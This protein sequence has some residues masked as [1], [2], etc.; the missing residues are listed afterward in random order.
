[1][2]KRFNIKPWQLILGVVLLGV[3]IYCYIANTDITNS[4]VASGMRFGM[5]LALAAMVGIM[6]E[7]S[8]V[9]NI[10][11]EG[12]ML[13]SGFTGF[14]IA[15]WSKNI[16][17]GLMIAILTGIL[18][19]FVHAM[20]TIQWKMDQIIAGTIINILASG[21]T[22]F[23]YKQGSTIP[24]SWPIFD[25]PILGQIPFIGHAFFTQQG[26][27]QYL[28]LILIPAIW[29]MMYKTRWGLR[30]RAVGE[31]PGS[32][33][34]AGVSVIK[35]RMINVMFGGAIGGFVGGF[36]C[37]ELVGS[38][39]KEFTAGSGFT[40]LALMIFGRWNPMGAFAAAIL[41]GLAQALS[42]QLQIFGVTN[43][44]N[45]FITMLP[46]VFTIVVLAVS[47]GKVR[48]PAAA[49]K[50]YEKEQA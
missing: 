50:S 22:S 18:T 14:Y 10:G 15:S 24:N 31:N 39:S 17:A 46:Y 36:I 9:I 7:R 40:A 5:P 48:P 1:M 45:Q 19:S 8:G 33:D 32:A 29:V 37:L 44:P 27:I 42:T 6:C 35:V 47:A 16:V 21:L 49:G 25:I 34:T 43:I 13:L 20:M 2:L 38:F 12:T 4:V 28:G 3:W 23:L 30:T 41:F 26:P 11:I